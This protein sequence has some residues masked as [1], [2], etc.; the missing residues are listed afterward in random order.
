MRACQSEVNDLAQRSMKLSLDGK[1]QAAVEQ[2]VAQGR[3]T[4]NA[5][6]IENAFMLLQRYAST[7]PR[8]EA[9]QQEVAALRDTYGVN[10]S[11]DVIGRDTVRRT[12]STTLKTIAQSSLDEGDDQAVPAFAD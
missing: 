6:L 4:M 5:K 11:R 1:H 8:A 10:H 7:V 2:L 3:E 12:S 9:L